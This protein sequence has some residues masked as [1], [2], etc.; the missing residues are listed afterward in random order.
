[1]LGGLGGYDSRTQTCS[2]RSPTHW[3]FLSHREHM[4]TIFSFFLRKMVAEV[5]GRE[6]LEPS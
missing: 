3:N 4:I 5:V 6:G 2:L 1:M